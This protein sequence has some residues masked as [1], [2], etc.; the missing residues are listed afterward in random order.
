MPT[1]GH[2]YIRPATSQDIPVLVELLVEGFHGGKPD[3]VKSPLR[4]QARD[5]V[6]KTLRQRRQAP[7]QMYVA[8]HSAD[9]SLQPVGM[10]RA[11]IRHHTTLFVSNLVVEE[12]ARNQGIGRALIRACELMARRRSCENIALMHDPENIPASVLYGKCG[13]AQI[14]DTQKTLWQSIVD[15]SILMQKPLLASSIPSE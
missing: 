9:R 7:V 4:I 5:M 15:K 12:S 3:V 6:A 8:T 1:R 14:D 11:E 10:V 13:F 2:I